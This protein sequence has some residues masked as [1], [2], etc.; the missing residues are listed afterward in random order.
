M[1]LLMYMYIYVTL[2]IIHEMLRKTRQGNKTQQKH[3]TT[4]PKQLFFKDKLAASS[5]TRTHDHQLSRRHSYQLSY[6]GSLLE[7]HTQSK[8]KQPKHLHV[9]VW[10]WICSVCTYMCIL[11]SVEGSGGLLLSSDGPDLTGAYLLETLGLDL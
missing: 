8:T 11:Q 7:T 4:H 10:M 5:G 3:N 2:I 1:V 6:R 9:H